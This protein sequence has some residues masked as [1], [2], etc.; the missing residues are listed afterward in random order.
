MV[1]VDGPTIGW[2]VA[3]PMALVLGPSNGSLVSSEV[4]A[5][6][7]LATTTGGLLICYAADSEEGEH[8]GSD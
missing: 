5:N 1:V 8:E 3:M 6:G 4:M 7:H 2:L